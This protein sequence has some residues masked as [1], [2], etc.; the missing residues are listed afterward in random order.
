MEELSLH[1]LDL[2][3]NSV[4][5]KATCVEI[6][7]SVQSDKN[8]LQIMIKD[9]GVGMSEAVVKRVADPFYTTR[10]TRKVGMG[11]PLFKALA[12]ACDGDLSIE[13]TC[14]EGTIVTATMALSHIDRPPMG[15]L[16]ESMATLIMCNTEIEFILICEVDDQLFRVDTV[17]IKQ[18]LNGVPVN[19][20]DVVIWLKE[21]IAEGL[22]H[23]YGGVQI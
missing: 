6:A 4:S 17:E 21:Y 15:G 2:A 7:I 1:I 18:I 3:Q 14:G 11:I 12:Q 23:T 5:A 19:H 20:P 10:T 16:A 22:K 9:N 8:R 13:S